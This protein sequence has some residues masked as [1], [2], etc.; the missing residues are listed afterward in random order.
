MRKIKIPYRRPDGSQVDA[1]GTC[2]TPKKIHEPWSEYE[3]EDGT[4]IRIKQTLMD[5]A[6]LDEEK[7][8]NGEP[9]YMFQFQQ[10]MT[11]ISKPSEN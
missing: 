5:L 11:I 7:T 8:P 4:I 3:L 10:A 9:V 1:V 2:V 6:C